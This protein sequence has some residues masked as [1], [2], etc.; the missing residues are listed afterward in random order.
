MEITTI[1]VDDFLENPDL[2]RESALSSMIDLVG[3]YPGFRSDPSDDEYGN[4]IK[5]KLEK[6]LN[7]QIVDWTSSFNY[8][9]DEMEFQETG[10]FQICLEDSKSWIHTDPTEWSAILYL[11]PNAPT[12]SG[13]A[14]Y[15]HKLTGIYKE[16]VFKEMIEDDVDT[17]EIISV[18]GNVYNRLALFKGQLYHKSLV[19]GFGHDKYS[20]RLTQ[21]FFF[22]T[23]SRIVE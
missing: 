21:V 1:I 15:R 6:I 17:W 3:N 5:A 16:S 13:T 11:T 23:S 10:K 18:I 9:K 7:T 12:D 4:Y 2:V 14:I 19:P 20:A 22:N 8:L